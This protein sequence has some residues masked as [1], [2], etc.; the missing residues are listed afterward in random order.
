M[1]RQVNIG[2]TLAVLAAAI[3]A[4]AYLKTDAVV[5]PAASVASLDWTTPTERVDGTPLEA[6]SGYRIYY[7]RDPE[8]L[9]HEIEVGPEVTKYEIVNLESGE[10]YFAVAAISG[11]GIESAPSA[12]KQK[13]IEE[14]LRPRV[15]SARSGSD[16]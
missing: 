3:L 16:R 15:A 1:N 10:W 13:T 14:P 7:G 11:D 5:D 4:F 9:E 12:I 6:V 2:A 8:Q